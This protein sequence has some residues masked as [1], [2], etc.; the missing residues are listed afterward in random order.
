MSRAVRM[1]EIIQLLRQSRRPLTAAEIGA[2]LEISKRTAYRD[3][4]ALQARRVPIEGAAGLGYVLRPGYELPPLTFDAGELE[5]LAVGLAL[6]A[7]T[8]DLGL[9][10]A[11]AR[12]AGKLTTALPRAAESLERP[13]L[14]VSGWTAVPEAG[15]EL[16]KLREAL[17]ENRAL[18][19]AYRDVEG[20][21]SRRRVLPLG[22]VYY[23][24][25]V[26]L[27]AWCR[28]RHDFRHFRVDRILD[29]A[30]SDEDFA[31]RAAA[32]RAKWREQL[33]LP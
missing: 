26:V 17:R 27:A 30:T 22:L 15:V 2:E 3:I 24:D 11:A 20:R 9:K 32:L 25:A 23:V 12:I 14:A 31:E 7:R 16:E 4:A 6:I 18:D 29:C 21:E 13:A 1:F 33:A 19:L 10:R 28:L 8:G 5:A